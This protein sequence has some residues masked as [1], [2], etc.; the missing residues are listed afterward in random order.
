[1]LALCVT[2]RPAWQPW[3]L[4]Q[5]AKQEHDYQLIVFDDCSKP[6][7]GWPKDTVVIR[8]ADRLKMTLGEKRQAVLCLAEPLD[9]PFA[10]F[11]DDDWHPKERLYMGSVML[12]PTNTVG[13]IPHELP[14]PT[15]VGYHAGI[16]VDVK[17]LQT[18]RLETGDSVTFNGAVFAPHCAK[19]RFQPMNRGEDTAW[20]RS[21]LKDATVVSSPV[22]QH[23]WMSHDGNVTGKR[24]SMTFEGARFS[25]FDSWEK[26]FLEKL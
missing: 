25:R 20:L 4:H 2:C 10:W 7:E 3:L 6:L 22:M 11:D 14:W 13:S 12:N 21:V 1:M 15:V 9:E 5:L 26:S 23:A 17:T 18:R 8:R 16:F 24:G 19:Q